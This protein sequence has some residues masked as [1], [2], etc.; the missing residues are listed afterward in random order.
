MADRDDVSEV[1]R[2]RSGR[3][4]GLRTRLRRLALLS[5]AGA[6]VTVGGLLAAAPTTAH[7]H[8]RAASA[9]PCPNL[10]EKLNFGGA[11]DNAPSRYPT[12]VTAHFP[13]LLRNDGA[14][15]HPGALWL[16]AEETTG[17]DA[18]LYSQ[19]GVDGVVF[20]RLQPCRVLKLKVIV[21]LASPAART[22]YVYLNL[23]SD[24]KRDGSWGDTVLCH[25]RVIPDHAVRD[26]PLLVR[27]GSLIT[28][29]QV[30]VLPGPGISP[31][32]S[33]AILTATPLGLDQPTG[34]VGDGEVED[35]MWPYSVKQLIGVGCGM[36]ALNVGTTGW[37]PFWVAPDTLPLFATRVVS[38]NLPLWTAKRTYLGPNAPRPRALPAGT[39]ANVGE[40]QYNSLPADI[41][42]PAMVRA[43]IVVG[44][45]T[46]VAHPKKKLLFACKFLVTRKVDPGPHYTIPLPNAHGLLVSP[47]QSLLYPLRVAIISAQGGSGVVTGDYGGL[48][49]PGVCSIWVPQ[50]HP[51]TLTATAAPGSLFVRWQGDCTG[52]E[53]TCTL[54]MASP[55]LALAE[56][57]KGFTLSVTKSG[58]GSGFVRGTAPSHIDCGNVCNETLPAGTVINLS[59]TPAAGSAF[60]DW[61]GCDHAPVACQVTLDA[62]R[63]VDA[64]FAVV[65]PTASGALGNGAGALLGYSIHTNEPADFFE[66]II[67]AGEDITG[68]SF[69]PGFSCSD[70]GDTE[71]CN[72]TVE[73]DTPLAG[74]FSHTGTIGANCGCVIVRFY[75]NHGV[76]FTAGATLSGP[77]TA[78]SAGYQ[79][80]GSEI[81]L[82]NNWNTGGVSGGGTEPSFS[83]GGNTYC[84]ISIGTYHWNGGSGATPGTIGLQ[85]E[86]G[87]LGP[88]AATGSNSNRDW[89]VTPGSASQPVIING[90]YACDDS[91]PATWSQNSASSGQGFCNVFVEAAQPS[92]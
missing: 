64:A 54:P 69:P 45:V 79:C 70:S 10:P 76:T 85:S 11:P 72:G 3:R 22:G 88:W 53:P 1:N 78:S 67:P 63:T 5:L 91:S 82:F 65:S 62:N 24:W 25:R 2:Q 41:P 55:S 80:V 13:T 21:H 40:I 42:G 46:N 71:E 52:T 4:A 57:T 51:V 84:L 60:E 12:G 48:H 90:T 92:G 89:Q 81:E 9:S 43:D 66:L 30:D 86:A 61:T 83:T 6:S 31:F 28:N 37:A 75:A 15:A 26:L 27:K 50:N 56:F 77:P 17:C 20:E 18:E 29:Y 23:W 35:Y 16:G 58:A 44:Y 34:D 14:R 33:R 8:G 59:E 49:C 68:M 19:A 38:S 39:K 73:P 36:G 7:D 47:L 32:W 87:T 74:T